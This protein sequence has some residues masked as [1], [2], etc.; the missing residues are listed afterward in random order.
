VPQ[1]R[2]KTKED[3]MYRNWTEIGK[4]KNPL[5]KALLASA[6]DDVLEGLS[7]GFPQ[8]FTEREPEQA[9]PW[10]LSA[11]RR[12]IDDAR[13][14]A[15]DGEAVAKVLA[16]RFGL[17]ATRAEGPDSYDEMGAVGLTLE[18]AENLILLRREGRAAFPRIAARLVTVGDVDYYASDVRC[19][20]DDPSS[21]R[22][23]LY[24]VDMVNDRA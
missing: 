8:Y 20:G 13:L 2:T 10:P 5:L 15:P 23:L 11:L 24:P 17:H 14:S 16:E 19:D 1:T 3:V 18:E 12:A 22:A 4:E 7:K 9:G 6:D 21:V